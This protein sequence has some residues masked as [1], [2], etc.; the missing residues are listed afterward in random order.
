MNEYTGG[1]GDDPIMSAKGLES[2]IAVA[3]PL[4][5]WTRERLLLEFLEVDWASEDSKSSCDRSLSI[6]QSFNNSFFHNN[7]NLVTIETID[8]FKI[9]N[10]CL[11]VKDFFELNQDLNDFS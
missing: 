5:C 2:C 10:Q 3:F 7:K 8:R 1:T 4:L 9:L 11:W 6:S